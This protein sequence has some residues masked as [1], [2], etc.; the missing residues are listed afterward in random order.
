[1]FRLIRRLLWW[2]LI[3]ILSCMY[4]T[5][6]MFQNRANQAFANVRTHV[7][8]LLDR[9]SGQNQ[10][11]TGNLTNDYDKGENNSS[12]GNQQR[13]TVPTTGRWATNRAR[14]YVDTGS[15]TL[16]NATRQAMNAWNQTGVF[17]FRPVQNRSQAEIVV[18][19]M[20]DRATNAAG[21]TESSTNP[22]N[23]QFAHADVYLNSYYL[24]NP[25]YGYSQQRII[26]TAEHELGHAIGLD[27]THI[28]SVMQPAGSFYSIQPVDIQT[29]RELYNE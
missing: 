4:F 13:T 22:L 17:T 10:P 2:S 23:R 14:V 26:N 15:K 7:E 9:N 1:M 20:N 19:A 24:T 5:D 6:H 18:T 3:L 29:V 28:T 27:H 25:M 16:D 12:N 8:L 21:L 11:T